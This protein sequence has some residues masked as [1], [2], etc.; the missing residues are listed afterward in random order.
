MVQS[1]IRK[2]VEASRNSVDNTKSRYTQGGDTEVFRERLGWWERDLETLKEDDTDEFIVITPKYDRR[3]DM[4]AA[5]FLGS[6]LL[7]WMVLQFNNIV[8][9]NEEFVAGKNIRLPTSRRVLFDFLNKST[10]GIPPKDET[11]INR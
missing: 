5:D 3:P 1:S 11:I 7:S 2:R 9:I 10:G 6:A 4:V 8:D